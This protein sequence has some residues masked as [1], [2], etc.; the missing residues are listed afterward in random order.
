M[1]LDS[2]ANAHTVECFRMYFQYFPCAFNFPCVCTNCPEAQAMLNCSVLYE[3]VS[4]NQSD[5]KLLWLFVMAKYISA[6]VHVCFL[7][8]STKS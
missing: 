4:S 8:A 5:N 1:F 7:Y 3:I 6:Y 2:H